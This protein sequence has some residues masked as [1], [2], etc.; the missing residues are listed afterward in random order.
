MLRTNRAK[1]LPASVLPNALLRNLLLPNWLRT[2][3]ATGNRHAPLLRGEVQN[4][5]PQRPTALQ[6]VGSRFVLR[7]V[8]LSVL[9]TLCS[10]MQ[11][12]RKS[13]HE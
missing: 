8:Q 5:E 10:V 4:S 13:R 2:E 7:P 9:C 11:S 12:L 6:A 3:F 1:L